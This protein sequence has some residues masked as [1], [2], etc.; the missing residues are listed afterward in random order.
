MKGEVYFKFLSHKIVKRTDLNSITLH[1]SQR[2]NRFDKESSQKN[3]E[4]ATGENFFELIGKRNKLTTKDL[5]FLSSLD[6]F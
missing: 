1:C 3:C 6:D 4:N 5:I 2:S